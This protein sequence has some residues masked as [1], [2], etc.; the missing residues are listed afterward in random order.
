MESR[1]DFQKHKGQ[2]VT[3]QS[4][5]GIRRTSKKCSLYVPELCQALEGAKLIKDK[6]SQILNTFYF[7]TFANCC[8]RAFSHFVF[9]AVLHE[10]ETAKA[11]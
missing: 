2:D 7:F 10:S 4:K 6:R 9:V 1:E 5:G 11:A 8:K 3:G